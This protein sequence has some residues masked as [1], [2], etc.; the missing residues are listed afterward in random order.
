[1]Q[2][3]LENR[4]FNQENTRVP[5]SIEHLIIQHKNYR[6]LIVFLQLKPL[7][8]SS[9][10]INDAGN[11]PYL[12]IAKFLGL[13]FS[14]LRGKIKQ[15]KKLKLLWVD[16]NK[17][18]HLASYKTFVSKFKPQ[19]LRRMKKYTYKN[20][21]SGDMLIKVSAIRNNLRKQSYVLKHKIINKEIYG[22]VN[23]PM[24][25]I[26]QPEGVNNSSFPYSDCHKGPKLTDM[27]QTAIRK[28]RKVLMNDYDNLLHK[29]KQ[30][31]LKQ[32]E[33]IEFGL[34]HINPYI[35]LSCDGLGRLFGITGSSGYYQR[36]KL[37]KAS[38][39]TCKDNYH[40]INSASPAVYENM[41][42]MRD[43]VFSY[44]YPVRRSI[45]GKEN[46]FFMRLSDIVT[47]NLN[48]IYENAKN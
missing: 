21:A 5:K 16:D 18:I 46:K 9:V 15:L 30:V 28:I 36:Q 10:I 33:Q 47:I 20:I 29:Q 43:N 42:N 37:V 41:N 35:T 40:K 44:N 13:S 11:L 2:S 1:M 12:P 4:I 3:S 32:M 27:S 26:K 6:A 7:Y 22:T 14:G 23:A 8:V 39:V 45:T 19:F 34:P 25:R 31:F 38:L 48:F 17:N 24:D